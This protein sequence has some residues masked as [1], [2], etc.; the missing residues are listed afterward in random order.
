MYNSLIL[1]TWYKKKIKDSILAQV[2]ADKNKIK[3]LSFP[4]EKNM[5]SPNAFIGDP[6]HIYQQYLKAFK[7]GVYNYVK[8]D[9]DPVTQ[10]TIPRK[11]F[12][13]GMDM[14]MT[15]SNYGLKAAFEI[16]ED[17]S[18]VPSSGLPDNAVVVRANI[19]PD[20]AMTTS[21]KPAPEK[22]Q[23]KPQV[24]QN[25]DEITQF[26]QSFPLSTQEIEE[27][28]EKVR[29]THEY[30]VKKFQSIAQMR[31]ILHFMQFPFGK[32]NYSLKNL[33]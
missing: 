1:A 25:Q 7:K 24:F 8:E 10:E 15:I 13:G 5:S 28:S 31:M 29:K 4:N 19:M 17:Q 23:V 32:L 22:P 9:I 21:S 6:E 3:G 26:L 14:S 27:W 16:I 20:I 12:S 11:Y 33:C 18:K 2:Y 30:F